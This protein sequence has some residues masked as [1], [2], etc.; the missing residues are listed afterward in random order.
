MKARDT[1]SQL[2]AKIHRLPAEQL[3]AVLKFVDSIGMPKEHERTEA[4]PK[5][6]QFPV[7]SVGRWPDALRLDREEMYGNDGR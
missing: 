3:A 4:A 1:H 6:F 7:V 2:L 5:P